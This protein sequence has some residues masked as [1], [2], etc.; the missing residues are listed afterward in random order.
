MTLFRRHCVPFYVLLILLSLQITSFRFRPQFNSL[1]FNDYK[2]QSFESNYRINAVRLN[3]NN[4]GDNAVKV[5]MLSQEEARRNYQPQISTE[6]IFQ[7]LLRIKDGVAHKILTEFNISLADTLE[8]TNVSLPPREESPEYSNQVITFSQNAKEALDYSSTIAERLGAQIIET[9]HLLLGVCND[10]SDNMIIFFKHLHV[11]P[12]VI[13]K[14]TLEYLE[15]LK[16]DLDNVSTTESISNP[17]SLMYA[18]GLGKDTLLASTISSFTTDF[19]KLA[20]EG[21]FHE[22]INRE[23]II[24]RA[25]RTLCRKTKSNVILIGEPGVG[26]TAIA[27][28]IALK[29]AK[30]EALPAIANKHMLM[31]EIGM[32][33]AG[34]K[35]RGQFEERLVKL[36]EDIKEMGNVIL[37][38]DEAHMLVGAGSG[39]GSIDAANLLKPALAR[40]EIQC[41]AI[42][43]PREYKKYFEKD[44]A[45]ARRFQ[46]IHVEE[47]SEGDTIEILNKLSDSYG[48]FHNVIYSPEAI[49]MAAKYS[50]QYISDRFLPDKAIDVLDESGSLAKLQYQKDSLAARQ[51][52]IDNPEHVVAD[53][54]AVDSP[55]APTLTPTANMQ[56]ARVQDSSDTSAQGVIATSQSAPKVNEDR[57]IVSTDHVAEIVSSW[58]GIPLKRLTASELDS[59]RNLEAELK[60]TIIGQDEAVTN[61]CKAI[62]RAKCQIKNPDRPIGTFLFCGPPGVG[63]SLVAKVLSRNLFANKSKMIRLDMSEYSEPHSISKILGSPPGYKGH[64]AGGQLTEK[65]RKMPYCVVMFDEIEKAH[66]DVLGV[67]LQILEDGKLTD[68]RNESV[69]F[70]NTIIIM[71]SNMGSNVIQRASRGV[72]E[73]GF[74]TPTDTLSNYNKIKTLVLEELKS[75]LKPELVNRIDEIIIFKPLSPEQML[76]IAELM[77]KDVIGRAKSAGLDL[78]VDKCVLEHIIKIASQQNGKF[79]EN[80]GAR[81][82]RRAITLVL[83]D[84]LAE[85]IISPLYHPGHAYVADMGPD[86]QVSIHPKSAL[87]LVDFPVDVNQSQS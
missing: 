54:T 10:S 55:D 15:Q 83:E 31:L 64:D 45:F 71:T 81:P 25:I 44:Q 48:K 18:S 47:P 69:S 86:A 79:G 73:F 19:T 84:P 17:F 66:P 30:G 77:V 6:H 59:V 56:D 34:T 38:I 49:T 52:Q 46:P 60:R 43:T 61:V 20:R 21:E 42:T 39:E 27:E 58:S 12:K 24:D 29:I 40:G 50:K 80:D 9:E 51:K 65:V 13:E 14:K 22:A 4:F 70:K 67:L 62:K 1:T 41:I 28:G 74:H 53:T 75:Q 8:A 87:T 85:I 76:E 3:F 72:F 35:F 36:L 33:L 2:H 11:D 63:K 26:K 78:T 57:I 7:G 32:L 16:K 82:L 5:L 37:V 68:S 23:D